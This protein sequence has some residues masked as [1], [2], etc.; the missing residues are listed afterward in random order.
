MDADE[1]TTFETLLLE[2][3]GLNRSVEDLESRILSGT[4][5]P[6]LKQ[7]QV[8]IAYIVCF[9]CGLALGGAAFLLM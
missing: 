3:T 6:S 5:I 2:D 8:Y 7:R 9:I 4:Y 1:R